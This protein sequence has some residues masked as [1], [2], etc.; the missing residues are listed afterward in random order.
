MEFRIL[1]PLEACDSSGAEIRLPA[2][3][4]RALF[5]ALLLRRGEVVLTDALIDALWGERPPS[6]ARS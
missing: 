1:G 5:A 2:G 3:R 4:E 6:T